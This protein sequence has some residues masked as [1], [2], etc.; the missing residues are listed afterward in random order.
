MAGSNIKTTNVEGGTYDQSAAL[1]LT[2]A[3]SGE[4]FIGNGSATL[5]GGGTAGDLISVNG[6]NNVSV[7]GLNLTNTANNTVWTASDFSGA[8]TGE[9]A[10]LA[11]NTS[12]DNFSYNNISN[13]GMAMNFQGVTDSQVDGNNISNVQQAIVVTQGGSGSSGNTIASNSIDNVSNVT[14]VMDDNQGAINLV[15]DSNDTVSNNVVQN[16]AAAGISI[17]TLSSGDTVNQNTVENTNTAATPSSTYDASATNPSDM[18]AIYAWTGAGNMTNEQ[19]NISNNYVQNAGQGIENN[20]IYLDDGVSGASVTGNIIQGAGAGSASFDVLVHGGSDNTIANNILNLDSASG[21][22]KGVFVQSDGDAM[23]GNSITGNTFYASGANG[24][25]I[26]TLVDSN[27]DI[28]ALSGNDYFGVPAPSI[29]SGA[30]TNNPGFVSPD[31]GNYSLAA[32]A[33]APIVADNPPPATPSDGISPATS[34]TAAS[35]PSD[36]TSPTTPMTTP[37]DNTSPATSTTTPSD[38]TSPVVSTSTVTPSDNAPPVVSTT[39]P[40]TPDSSTSPE[41]AAV[42][43]STLSNLY[44]ADMS[45][46]DAISAQPTSEASMGV[47]STGDPALPANAASLSPLTINGDSGLSAL[48]A[49]GNLTQNAD[50]SYTFNG[51]GQQVAPLD[52]NGVDNLTITNAVFANTGSNPGISINGDSNDIV[53]SNSAFNQVAYGI[54]VIQS[55]NVDPTNIGI[56]NNSFSNLTG[57]YP[58]SSAI[59]FD[60]AG[61]NG[62]PAAANGENLIANNTINGTA[63]GIANNDGSDLISLYNYANGENNAQTLVYS[64]QISGSV[65][66]PGGAQTVGSA[67]NAEIDPGVAGSSEPAAV[68]ANNFITGQTNAGIGNDGSDADIIGNLVT[69]T[70]SDFN[71]GPEAGYNPSGAYTYNKTDNSPVVPVAQSQGGWPV[72]YAPDGP[73]NDPGNTNSWDVPGTGDSTVPAPPA[74]PS[75]GDS[76]PPA[77]TPSDSTP[78]ATPTDNTTPATSTDTA[79]AATPTDTAPAATPTDAAPP[80]APTTPLNVASAPPAAS[81]STAY[82]AAADLAAAESITSMPASAAA[83]TDVGATTTPAALANPQDLSTVTV[84]GN[85]DITSA[86]A[87]LGTLTE[88]NG[89]YTLDANGNQLPPLVLNNVSNLNITNANFADVSGS[90]AVTINGDSSGIAITNSNFAN[91][92]SGVDI[93]PANG[94]MPSGITIDGNSFSDITGPWPSASAVQFAGSGAGEVAADP[95]GT[96]SVSHNT[97]ID[98]MS[99]ASPNSTDASLSG[100]D[101]MSDYNNPYNVP[102]VFYSNFVDGSYT[103]ADGSHPPDS[104]INAEMSNDEWIAGNLA[105]NQSN[106][107]FGND[108]STNVTFTGNYAVNATYAFGPENGI[109]PTGNWTYNNANTSPQTSSGWPEIYA[110]DGLP[111]APGDTNN[112]NT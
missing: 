111:N 46:V 112:W 41:T 66:L 87:G 47:G 17:T 58:A 53:V 57:S 22:E 67:I 88:N 52:L 13:V 106:A 110:P 94:V 83:M 34:T 61:A 62:T 26:D 103:P 20:G 80:A 59:Q 90:G 56:V 31:T 50:G 51:N 97:V 38:N 18:G 92:S 69:D 74:A 2:S 4:S 82:S 16:T 8:G 95:N 25:A 40:V 60:G 76:T 33:T 24:G 1:T 49:Y 35:T 98:G 75:V 43:S 9:D 77:T 27:S 28:P 30:A 12:G 32:N 44:A 39:T 93:Y 70:A 15:G 23:T 85:S 104:A 79:P 89:T 91:I 37:G 6:A 7:E 21:Q 78:A 5:N 86:L 11:Q 64:N 100:Q 63:S 71:V 48:D 10:I 14:G 108:G 107:S 109:N 102:T 105:E 42:T 45:A 68:I 55:N 19:L 72:V 3:D 101:I 81:G 29:D 54:G 65:E 96:N 73:P 84:N 99:L 36:N